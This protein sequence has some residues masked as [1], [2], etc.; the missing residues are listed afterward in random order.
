MEAIGRKPEGH[1]PANLADLP[2]SSKATKSAGFSSRRPAR[3]A[4]ASPHRSRRRI[5]GMVDQADFFGRY[6]N[7]PSSAARTTGASMFPIQNGVA[8]RYAPVITW[9]LIKPD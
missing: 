4:R 3:G 8:A 5:G 6:R 2:S 1:Q 7:A 9:C